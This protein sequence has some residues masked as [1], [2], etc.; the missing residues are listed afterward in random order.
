MTSAELALHSQAA[1]FPSECA[2]LLLQDHSLS[3]EVLEV[4]L[5]QA[6]QLGVLEGYEDL[7]VHLHAES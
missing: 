2:P 4:G 1:P 3:A 6:A 7:Q 5:G